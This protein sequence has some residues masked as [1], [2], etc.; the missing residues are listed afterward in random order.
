[1]LSGAELN[2]L[3]MPVKFG[4]VLLGDITDRRNGRNVA[5]HAVDAFERDDLRA[6]RRHRSH[7]FIEMSHVVVATSGWIS[8]LAALGTL[9]RLEDQRAFLAVQVR[10]LGLQLDMMPIGAGDVSGAAG[11]RTRAIERPVHGRQHIGVLAHPQ[12][13]VAA[14]HGHATGLAVRTVPKGARELTGDP[15]QLYE[16]PISAIQFG[17]G[18]ERLKCRAKVRFT[19]HL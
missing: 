6:L 3:L 16:G 12:I 15:L 17:V 10:K 4:A 8:N 11:A 5:V 9:G 18:N 1:M 7:Q 2:Q 14:P 19:V 13:V